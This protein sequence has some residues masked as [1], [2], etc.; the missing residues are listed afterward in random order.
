MEAEWLV[1]SGAGQDRRLFHV[2]PLDSTR[3]LSPFIDPGLLCV[4]C[5]TAALPMLMH[6]V[7]HQPSDNILPLSALLL[8]SPVSPQRCPC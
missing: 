2:W 1:C 7:L 8:A 6:L 4:T 3:P 5:I